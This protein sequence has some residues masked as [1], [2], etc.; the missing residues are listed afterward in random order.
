MI[1]LEEVRS[2]NF[3]GMRDFVVLLAGLVIATNAKLVFEIGTGLLSSGKSFLYGLEKTGGRLVSCDVVKRFDFS[4]PR[5]T[6]IQQ[7]STEVAKYWKS[8]IDI[9][10]IDGIHFADA[11]K[12]DFDSFFPFVRR[13]GLAVLHDIAHRNVEERGAKVLIDNLKKMKA[14]VGILEFYSYPGLAI[15][16]KR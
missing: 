16:Q 9:L 6:F 4:H 12:K 13:M 5:F 7:S 1:D 3:Y 15:V 2:D 8:P 14:N 11:V 10:F